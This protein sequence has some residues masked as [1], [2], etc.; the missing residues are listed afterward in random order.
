MQ[1]LI[2]GYNLMHAVGMISS[3][4]PPGAFHRARTRFLDWLADSSKDRGVKLRVVFDARGAPNSSPEQDHRDVKVVFAFRETAD[5]LIESLITAEQ[6][7]NHLTVVSNDNQV[8]EAGRRGGGQVYSCEDFTDWLI[9][10]ATPETLTHAPPETNKP[11]PTASDDEMA[12]W[13]NVF[14]TPPIK[15]GKKRKKT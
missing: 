6:Q 11:I 1:Y 15:G 4:S 13:L 3:R 9:A 14:S 8:R 2:D 10:G 5:E 12:T 7:P